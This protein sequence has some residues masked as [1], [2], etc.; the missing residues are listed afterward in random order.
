MRL[1]DSAAIEMRPTSSVCRNWPRPRFGIAD[2]VLVG[3]PDVVEEQLA[4]VE[5][6]PTDAAHLRPHGEPGVS[7]STTKRGVGGLRLVVARDAGQQRHAEGHVGAGVG[8][9]GLAAVDQPPAVLALGPGADAAGVGAG[10]GLGEAEGPEGT[11]LGQRPQPPLALL[12]VA[13]Q[14]QGQR[15]DGDVG[16]PRGGD[17][18]VGQADLLHGG[19]E[20]DRGH[21]DPAPLLGDEHAEQPELAHLAEQVGGAPR[22]LPRHGGAGRDLLLGEVAAEVGQVLFGFGEGEVHRPV[23]LWTDRSNGSACGGQ[24]CSILRSPRSGVHDSTTSLVASASRP[25]MTTSVMTATNISPVRL[26]RSALPWAPIRP[27]SLVPRPPPRPVN[28]PP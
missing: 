6:L 24:S 3:H 4:G 17:G 7:F 2:E 5:A 16:L 22:L 26:A 18:L 23:I 9:E 14:E 19:D 13:E 11:A 28:R 12:V 1:S 15:A 21:P 8:D 10:V 27:L 25:L 20:A